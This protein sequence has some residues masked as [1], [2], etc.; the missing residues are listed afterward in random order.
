M[1]LSYT[2][3]DWEPVGS[4]TLEYQIVVDICNGSQ[5]TV[6][7]VVENTS[8]WWR[9]GLDRIRAHYEVLL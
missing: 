6:W 5:H 9:T 7:L 3:V 2:L 8:D 4:A 1:P